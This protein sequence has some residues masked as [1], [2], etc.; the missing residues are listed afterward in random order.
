MTQQLKRAELVGQERK[1]LIIRVSS[2][3][4]SVSWRGY[5]LQ[6]GHYANTI[7]LFL[8]ATPRNETLLSLLCRLGNWGL[9]ILY[10]LPKVT[11]PANDRK[12]C[13]FPSSGTPGLSI[14]LQ[15]LPQQR[16]RRRSHVTRQCRDGETAEVRSNCPF[17]RKG[18]FRPCFLAFIYALEYFLFP[19]IMQNCLHL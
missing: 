17:P 16:R 1:N 19:Y 8:I 5:S 3:R 9:E 13:D 18:Y 2:V 12:G 15:I 14:S 10:D 7:R 6:A 11:Q 4:L